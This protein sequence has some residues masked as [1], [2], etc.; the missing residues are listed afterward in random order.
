MRGRR[1]SEVLPRRRYSLSV[2][3]F[4][5][6]KLL[7][8]TLKNSFLFVCSYVHF[9]FVCVQLFVFLLYV[10]KGWSLKGIAAK[11]KE[12]GNEG[13]EVSVRFYRYDS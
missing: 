1:R 8:F 5:F 9:L 12:S 2:G 7:R 13:R 6:K 11:G 3:K 4:L 10:A